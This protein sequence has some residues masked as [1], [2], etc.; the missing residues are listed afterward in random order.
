[1]Q[2]SVSIPNTSLDAEVHYTL[3][4]SEPIATSPVATKEPITINKSA[5]IKAKIFFHGRPITATSTASFEKVTPKPALDVHPERDGLFFSS[6]NG[7][8]T[9]LPEFAKLELKRANGWMHNVDLFNLRGTEKYGYVFEGWIKIPRAGIYTF[10]ISSD[11]GSKL[12]IDKET[13]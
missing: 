3:D 12:L 9:Q 1:D 5:T 10:Y 4:G 11:D 6:Y 13:L 2:L 8:W 7:N